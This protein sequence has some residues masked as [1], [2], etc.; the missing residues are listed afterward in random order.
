MASDAFL[1]IEW[2]NG[3]EDVALIIADDH[4]GLVE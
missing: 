2:D 1:W 3:E 4:W